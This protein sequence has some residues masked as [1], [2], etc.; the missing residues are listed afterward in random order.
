MLDMLTAVLI[1]IAALTIMVALV[2]IAG[3]LVSMFAAMFAAPAEHHR[4]HG[5]HA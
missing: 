5:A 3:F 1:G 4:Q 2:M